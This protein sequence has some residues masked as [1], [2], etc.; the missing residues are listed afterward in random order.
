MALRV[1]I[2]LEI[3]PS[4]GDFINNCGPGL[5]ALPCIVNYTISS[6]SIHLWCHWCAFCH[7]ITT[8]LYNYH[9]LCHMKLHVSLLKYEIC[10]TEFNK[11]CSYFFPMPCFSALSCK[12]FTMFCFSFLVLL[13]FAFDVTW[14]ICHKMENITHER[15][16]ATDNREMQENKKK[17]EIRM[18]CRRSNRG[19]HWMDGRKEGRI[20]A[21]MDGSIGW[22]NGF[23]EKVIIVGGII[24]HLKKERDNRL[25]WSG[26]PCT[27]VPISLY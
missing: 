18:G 3:S 6:S 26:G 13:C 25:P 16:G 7:I 24:E 19:R 17:V 20:D 21:W 5:P 15:K 11:W 27:H 10:F 8:I 2:L 4:Q 22:E 1:I 14:D 12:V 23:H 9:A